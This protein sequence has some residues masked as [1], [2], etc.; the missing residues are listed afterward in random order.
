[1]KRIKKMTFCFLAVLILC[2]AGC[3]DVGPVKYGDPSD[4]SSDKSGSKEKVEFSDE[5]LVGFD[6]G[7]SSWGDFYDCISVRVIICTNR[8]V[9]VFARSMETVH[10]RNGELEQIAKL[11]LTE[12]QYSNIEKKLDRE[13]LYNM[14]I[15]SD[16]GACDGS[17][18]YLILYDQDK[19]VAKNCG[20]YMPLTKA[21]MNVYDSVM[22]N[23]PKEEL[24]E[25]R[26]AYVEAV[27]KYENPDPVVEK[28]CYQAY[29][30][31]LEAIVEWERFLLI[32]VDG[33]KTDELVETNY[34]PERDDE[35]THR[36]AIVDWQENELVVTEY[37][38]E[39]S[40]MPLSE[41]GY[42]RKDVMLAILRIESERY[43]EDVTQRE[44][45]MFYL[46]SCHAWLEENRNGELG[47]RVDA[48]EDY[49]IVSNLGDTTDDSHLNENGS[50]EYFLFR[51]PKSEVIRFYGEVIGKE[52]TYETGSDGSA[53]TG[54]YCGEDG[55]LYV[56][57]GDDAGYYVTVD[58][59]EKKENECIVHASVWNSSMNDRLADVTV[60][61]TPTGGKYGYVLKDYVLQK[62]S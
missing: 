49:Q 40:K 24:R 50:L 26:N 16:E 27:R 13:K 30:D 15:K 1:M 2:I 46:V 9:L 32:D 58:D 6:F 23:I 55:W 36:Y 14:K 5:Y 25:I 56:N 39:T 21:F 57:R 35:G 42:Q 17:S 19:N 47:E 11:S 8:D 37:D 7:G 54:V 29:G 34:N 45:T 12:D 60:T 43:V 28:N 41:T 44:R 20:A 48:M 3:S 31:Y 38:G 22:D 51:M 62:L 59:F 53:E 33:D 4:E 18:Y 61:L 52:R 10:G